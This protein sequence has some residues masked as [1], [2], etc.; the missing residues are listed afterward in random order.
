[1]LL[2]R[3][4]GL[5]FLI[6]IGVAKVLVLVLPSRNSAFNFAFVVTLSNHNTAQRH[7]LALCNLHDNHYYANHCLQPPMWF[8]SGRKSH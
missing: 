4:V 3:R 6:C 8:P 1:M 2:T 7:E 5:T